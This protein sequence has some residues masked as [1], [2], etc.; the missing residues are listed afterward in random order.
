MIE[1]KPKQKNVNQ[2]EALRLRNIVL[3]WLDRSKNISPVS[4]NKKPQPIER[5]A[6]EPMKE[7]TN[8]VSQVSAPKIFK[9]TVAEPE[10]VK[11]PKPPQAITATSAKPNL[12]PAV[13]NPAPPQNRQA[14]P[15]KQLPTRI[16]RPI[17]YQKI[18][19]VGL[20]MIIG[21]VVGSSAIVYGLG[22]NNQVVSALVKIVPYPAVIVNWQLVNYADWQSQSKVLKNFYVNQAAAN[23]NITVPADTDIQRHVLERM[24]EKVILEQQARHYKIQVNDQELDVYMEN[25]AD[26]LG[27]QAALET[28]IETLYQW[29]LETFK[30]EIV[31]PLILKTQL[32]SAIVADD[33]LSGTA[34]Q[35]A[36]SVLVE[37]EDGQKSFEDLAKQYGQDSTAAE[38]GNLGYLKKGQLV[39]AL[40]QVAFSLQVGEVSEIIQTQYGFHIIKVD[41]IVLD[42]QDQVDQVKVR[43]ILIR[44][45][46]LS[47]F[48]QS[49]KN[50]AMIW[51]LVSI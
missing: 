31:R 44:G 5:P 26:E 40:D 8:P 2:E 11:L 1:E 20:I 51:R 3:K 4:Q 13:K 7:I 46:D 16:T 17:N 34:R 6:V 33:R 18:L 24:I 22:P 42:E 23:P 36:Q 28:Q 15:L 41:E 9:L 45:Q 27:S 21:V 30:Q 25:L 43:H 12:P 32:A 14:K 38:G 10:L 29:S 39:T 35:Q 48:L 19:F 47:D 49:V 50:E 37:I